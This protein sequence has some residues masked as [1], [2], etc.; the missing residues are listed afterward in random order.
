MGTSVTHRTCGRCSI[1]STTRKIALC[2]SPPNCGSGSTTAPLNCGRS[3]TTQKMP[4]RRFASAFLQ[5]YNLKRPPRH[6]PRGLPRTR[7]PRYSVLGD[8]TCHLKKKGHQP[9]TVIQ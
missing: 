7:T 8:T 6:R 4:M 3:S 9:C 1:A 5:G 2:H